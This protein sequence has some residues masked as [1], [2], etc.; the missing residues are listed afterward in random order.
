[1]YRTV[2]VYQLEGWLCRR[3]GDPGRVR[4]A[5][6]LEPAEGIPKLTLHTALPPRFR[7]PSYRDSGGHVVSQARLGRR[8]WV[9]RSARA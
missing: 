2:A 4:C 1:M 8:L 7:G 3:A 6:S 9:R 5:F